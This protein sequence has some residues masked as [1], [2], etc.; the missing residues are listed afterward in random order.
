MPS[1]ELNA[2]NQLLVNSKM[3]DAELNVIKEMQ[4]FFEMQFGSTGFFLVTSSGSSQKENESVKLI[5]L[6]QKSV[7]NS[8]KRFNDYFKAGK[9]DHWG[10]VL[11]EFHVAGLGVYAR[12]HLAGSEVFKADWR[13]EEIADWIK[14]NKISYISMVPAQV[15]D[16][17]Q[18]KIKSPVQI[19]KIFVGAGALNADLKLSAQELGWPIIETYGMTETCSMIAVKP[20][21]DFYVMPAVEVGNQSGSLSIKCD[22]LLTASLQ[23]KADKIFIEK[24]ATDSWYQTQDSVELQES[25]G[26]II[27]KFLGRAGDYIK[28]LGEGVSLSELR[29][30]LMQLLLAQKYNVDSFAL[31][32]IGDARSENKLI[33]AVENSVEIG[34][35]DVVID[36]FN[37]TSRP[38]ERIAQPVLV[39]RI[40]RTELGKLK[41]DELKRIV[42][43]ELNRGSNG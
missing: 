11:P 22:S 31:L 3:T 23:K 32:A 6:S 12:A 4:I 15:F 17:V 21:H 41:S 29:D 43:S 25:Q 20:A 5:A 10:L 38:Y 7:L 14:N 28:I 26:G 40:P 39:K 36:L 19:K 35:A 27:L 18:N 42:E 24:F 33:L 37:K 16:L 13:S 1:F 34:R 8:A 30:K 2:K 9:E